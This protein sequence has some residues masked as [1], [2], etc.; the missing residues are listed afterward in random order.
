MSTGH[1][2]GL[3]ARHAA[4]RLRAAYER[5]RVVAGAG[6]ACAGGAG[7]GAAHL[8]AVGA[9]WEGGEVAAGLSVAHIAAAAAAVVAFVGV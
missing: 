2:S 4:A 7:A 5:E 1:P 6:V 9:V 8:K 3:P